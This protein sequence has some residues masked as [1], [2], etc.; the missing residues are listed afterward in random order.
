MTA[1]AMTD[2][3]EGP[4]YVAGEDALYFTTKPVPGDPPRVD[5]KR[6][7]L[8]TGAITMVRP[9]ANVANGMT[10]G[11][12]GRLIVCEQGSFHEPARIS[13]VDRHTGAAQTIVDGWEERPLNSPNDVVVARDGSIWFTDPSYGHLQ[14][15]RPA[16]AAG[17]HV[18]RHDPA[19][20]ETTMVADGFDKPNGLAFSPDGSVLYVADNGAPHHLLAFPVHE[21]RL[22]AGRVI[23]H[24]T[25][26]HP[27]G[28][29]VDADGRIYVS[30]PTG[31]RVHAPDGALLGEIEAPG[32]VNFCFGPDALLI[33]TDTAIVA[34]KGL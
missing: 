18:Y 16:P 21:G 7:D 3:H 24:G 31:V 34:A 8:A 17:D 4:V 15:F 26:G 2:A 30:A 29:K 6:L 11:P 19:T 25:P 1:V 9:D 20:G 33:T 10:L 27:D 13:A 23:A 28:L 12:D 14:G 22:G 32:A 5:I